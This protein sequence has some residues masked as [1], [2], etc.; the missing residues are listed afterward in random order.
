MKHC[1]MLCVNKKEMDRCTHNR[2]AVNLNALP[3]TRLLI[4]LN[5]QKLQH[6]QIFTQVLKVETESN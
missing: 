1:N 6:T 3:L 4:L 5:K 2:H